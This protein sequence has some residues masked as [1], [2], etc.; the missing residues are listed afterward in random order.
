MDEGKLQN[1]P[2]VLPLDEKN[3][4]LN[5]MKEMGSFKKTELMSLSRARKSWII[6]GFSKTRKTVKDCDW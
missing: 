1:Y 3:V 6:D 4:W 5:A 2:Q